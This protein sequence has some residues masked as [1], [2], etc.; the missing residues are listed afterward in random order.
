MTKPALKT[1]L[2]RNVPEPMLREIKSTAALEGRP[3]WEL[4][5]EAVQQYL[6]TQNKAV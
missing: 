2:L 6:D 5:L 1:Y 3:M 4:I